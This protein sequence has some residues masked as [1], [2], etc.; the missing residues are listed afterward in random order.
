MILFYFY[1]VKFIVCA[2]A[3]YFRPCHPDAFIFNNPMYSRLCDLSRTPHQ[4]ETRVHYTNDNKFSI[5]FLLILQVKVYH[6]NFY[7]DIL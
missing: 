1:H 7:Y 3:A 4:Y 5:I 6:S 2:Y